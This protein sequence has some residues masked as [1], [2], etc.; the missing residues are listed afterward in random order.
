MS[1]NPFL[2]L[3]QTPSPGTQV[4]QAAVHRFSTRCRHQEPG[5]AGTQQD[6]PGG[7]RAKTTFAHLAAVV[8]AAA[9]DVC[10]QGS[11]SATTNTGDNKQTNV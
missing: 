5:T 3:E 1:V 11:D 2:E 4:D 8:G 9:M 7:S 10:D 6:V